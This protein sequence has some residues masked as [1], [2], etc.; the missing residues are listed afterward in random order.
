MTFSYKL[1]KDQKNLMLDYMEGVCSSS[2]ISKR[3]LGNAIRCYHVSYPI[4][5][6]LLVFYA[7]KICVQ[8]IILSLFIAMFFF[9]ICN[10]CILTMLENRLCGDEFTLADLWIEMMDLKLDNK[11]R[12]TMSFV[13]AAGFCTFVGIIYAIRFV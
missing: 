2:K 1:S 11:A 9:I 6:L 10:G 3:T 7:S 13:I 8:V 12:M 4:F 5:L